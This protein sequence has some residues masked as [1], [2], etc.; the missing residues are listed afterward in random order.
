VARFVLLCAAAATLS[1][2]LA[3]AQSRTDDLIAQQKSGLQAATGTARCPDRGGDEI[4]VCG[5]AT[6]P[7]RLPLP[8]EPLPGAIERG[9]VPSPVALTKE[10]TCTNIGQTRGCPSFDI[11]AIGLMIGKAVLEQVVKEVVEDE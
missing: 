1:P 6:S 7:Y 11:L 9:V 2:S 3:Q 5:K 4:V 10:E 8:P